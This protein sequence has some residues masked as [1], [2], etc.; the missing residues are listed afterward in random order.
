[1][2]ALLDKLAANRRFEF[3]STAFPADKF[4]VV[5]ME[6][7]EAISRPFRFS[8]TLVTDDAD[9]DFDAM[10]GN[11][12]VM[13][14]HAPDGRLAVPYHGVLSEFEQ[15]HAANGYFF[16]RA[17]LVPRLWQL[18]LY[19]I[20]EAYLNEQTIPQ[21]LE[22][23]L[24][25]SRLLAADYELKL[26]GQYRPRSFVC[27][28]EETHL[29]FLSRWMEKEGMYYYFDHADQADKLVV[30][31]SRLMHDAQALP[32]NY[33]PADTLDTG[34]TADAVQG[35]VCRQKPLP[36]SVVLLEFNYRKA[37]VP[38]KVQATVSANGIGEVMIYGENFRDEAEGQ[39]YA[40]LRA[41]EILCGGKVFS[42]EST[43]VGLRSGYFMQM[44]G[45]Y[46]DGFNGRYLVT[47]VHHEG[48]QAGALLNGMKTP[49]NDDSGVETRYANSFR[50]IPDAVQFRAERT[51]PRPS[52]AGTLTATVDA[53]G[54]GQYAEL[55]EYGQYKVQLPFDRT[56]KAGAKGSARVR[57]A[58][59]YSGSDHG[60]HF[61]LHKG[62]EVLL[63]F[64]DGDPDQPVIV[65]AVPNSENVSLVNQTN[66][67][68]NRIST[69]GGNQVYLGDG[70]GK[71]VIWMRSPFHNSSI[72]IG[73][74]D[75]KGGGSILASTGGSSVSLS[76]GDAT[77]IS[78]GIKTTASLS[79]ETSLTAA[80]VNKFALGTS[81]NFTAGSDVS[82]KFGRGYT[83]DDSETVVLKDAGKL[84]G[85]KDV[86][87]SGGQ[88]TAIAATVKTLV[89]QIKT[90]VAANIA[91][92]VLL[93]AGAA[94]AVAVEGDQKKGDTQKG[95]GK[96]P[97]DNP[98]GYGALAAHT[99]AMA[100]T[101]GI[102]HLVL[103]N[104]AAALMN[105]IKTATFTSTLKLGKSRLFASTESDL[106]PVGMSN[107]DMTPSTIALRASG[108]L[109]GVGSSVTVG[110]N[111][112]KIVAGELSAP[113]PD[114]TLDVLT[115]TGVANP[116]LSSSLTVSPT[117]ANLSTMNP[118]GTVKLAQPAGGSLEIDATKLAA[119]SGLTN[120]ELTLAGD[121]T[122][123]SGPNGFTVN[124]N[125][126]MASAFASDLFLS[127]TQATLTL[128]PNGVKLN[129]ATA[130]VVGTIVKIG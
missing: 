35:F 88:R 118:A 17:V 78:G 82:W 94:A 38:L 70:E 15:L 103:A 34:V 111:D 92:N 18:S 86:T 46:R 50:A 107:I 22:S 77:A 37:A 81:V 122:L 25:G 58:T 130:S 1:M 129:A 44:A 127:S 73:S 10:L 83:V 32:V 42:G 61:P 24:R 54:S 76:A 125:S 101:T 9:V 16:Y 110:T 62:S 79:L 120:L 56:D 96:L 89:A 84:Q 45:H 41:E 7:F 128:G 123:A 126:A 5:E 119:K 116:A 67:E 104:A 53:E 91:V 12:A 124:A 106:P 36:Q 2:V 47:E 13:H 112:V 26:V 99:G 49:F 3:A 59:P 33:R 117:G 28:Y 14:I 114:A 75:P 68:A 74:V 64:T 66:P 52:V 90:V 100:I 30:A 115:V 98:W 51:T 39:R 31:D 102:S 29:D 57:M 27:Q 8:L 108:S 63:A 97:V 85:N 69:A 43:A 95:D 21:I 105:T 72:G 71:E 87:I 4:A 93:A 55:D 109:G 80:F 60:M 20:S 48:S 23:V 11:P 113:L 40:G 6:G 65:A 121:A 19:R